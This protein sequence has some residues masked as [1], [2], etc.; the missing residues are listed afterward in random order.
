MKWIS[1]KDRLPEQEGMYLGCD[2]NIDIFLT[3]YFGS[4]FENSEK[5]LPVKVTHWMPLPLPPKEVER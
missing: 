4:G 5:P 3:L 1:I 2:S